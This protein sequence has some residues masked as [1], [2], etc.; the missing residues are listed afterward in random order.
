MTVSGF[1]KF[2]KKAGYS[3]K[4][5]LLKLTLLLFYDDKSRKC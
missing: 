4:K 2:S 1:L 5:S 3:F